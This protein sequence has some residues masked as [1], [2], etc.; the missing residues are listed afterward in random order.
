MH[1]GPVG[2]DGVHQQDRDWLGRVRE[3]DCPTIC[4]RYHDL[5]VTVA[6]NR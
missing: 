2:P 3:Q 1:M 6:A 4:I 5:M